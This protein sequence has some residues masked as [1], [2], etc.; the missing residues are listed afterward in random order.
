MAF[1]ADQPAA[2]ADLFVSLPVLDERYS[3]FV[4]M[5]LRRTA[6]VAELR[7][8]APDTAAVIL[9]KAAGH[10]IAWGWE[11]ASTAAFIANDHYASAL[12]AKAE[13]ARLS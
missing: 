4:R 13:R 7:L 12:L 10:V 11:Q 6:L 2:A 8:L 3:H 1:D 9:E 5:E